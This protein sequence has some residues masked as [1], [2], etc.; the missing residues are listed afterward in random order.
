MPSV[1]RSFATLILGLVFWV[2]VLCS[3]FGFSFGVASDALLWVLLGMLIGVLIAVLL[4]V[5]RWCG[6]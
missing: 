2:L 3:R 4:G 5:L 6:L 1:V